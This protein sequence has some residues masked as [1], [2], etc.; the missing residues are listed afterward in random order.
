MNNGARKGG[1]AITFDTLKT[2][3]GLQDLWQLH[4][5]ISAKDKNTPADFIANT[6]EKCEGKAIK[7]SVQRDGTFTVTNM[8]NQFSKTYKP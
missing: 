8:R 5:S 4:A 2:S 7:V 6:E 1:D 3:P